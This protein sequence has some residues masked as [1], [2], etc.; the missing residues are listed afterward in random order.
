M[1]TLGCSTGPVTLDL[2]VL[3]PLVNAILTTN[4][5]LKQEKVSVALIINSLLSFLL[6]NYI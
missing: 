1:L 5:Y 6:I 3:L 4:I 2:S